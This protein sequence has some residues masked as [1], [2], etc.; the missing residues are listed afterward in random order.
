MKCTVGCTI[1]CTVPYRALH[2]L[3]RASNCS[4]VVWDRNA[5]QCS[6]LRWSAVQCAVVWGGSLINMFWRSALLTA[7]S[8]G[9]AINI[10]ITH[11]LLH[12]THQVHSKRKVW[13]IIANARINHN[14]SRTLGEI[15]GLSISSWNPPQLISHWF[16]K[17]QLVSQ[18]PSF[19]YMIK[20]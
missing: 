17:A 11:Y 2:W 1:Q 12:H 13:L 14:Q 10:I 7:H 6:D 8:P 9:D 20:T 16:C 5:E 19:L 15:F 3:F 4:A 18:I